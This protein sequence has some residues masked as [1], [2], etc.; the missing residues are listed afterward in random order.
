MNTKNNILSEIQRYIF[1]IDQDMEKDEIQK[2][3]KALE[4]EFPC[5]KIKT[6]ISMKSY[7]SYLKKEKQSYEFKFIYYIVSGKLADKFFESYNSHTHSNII[8]ATIVYCG[9]KNYY[10]SKPYA[11]DLYFNPGGIVTNF[12]EVIKY[13]RSENDILWHNLANINKNSI[14]LP[15]E[16][17][18]FG[19]TFQYA[20]TLSDIALPIIL[21]EIIKKI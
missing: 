8:A 12:N 7:E 17:Q 14:I 5:Y 18:N 16:K 21:T 3:L 4:N 9:N 1:W 19:N 15:E 6:F 2:C 20:Q 11:N 10:S 13:I